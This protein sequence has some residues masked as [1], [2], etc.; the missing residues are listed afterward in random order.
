MTSQDPVAVIARTLAG[1]RRDA[2]PAAPS[3][4]VALGDSFTAGTGC[5]AGERWADLL[6]LSLRGAR[7]DLQYRNLAFDGATSADVLEQ[8]GP[9]LEQEPDLVTVVC[10]GNDVLRSLRPDIDAYADRMRLIFVRLRATLPALTLVT[11]TAPGRWSFLGLG[12]RT[13]ARVEDA[14]SRLNETTKAV[15]S[16]YG[17]LCLDLAEHPGL[18]DPRNFCTDGL[19]PSEQGHARAAREFTRLLARRMSW[20]LNHQPEQGGP[21]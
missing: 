21:Q 12:P 15:A 20:T 8:V 1:P 10:G 3:C 6:A 13:R 4:Y 11:A 17:A 5:P 14:V 9:A 18:D 16:T 19:H 7:P 2:A